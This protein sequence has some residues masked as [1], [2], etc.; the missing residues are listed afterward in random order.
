MK[1]LTIIL[2]IIVSLGWTSAHAEYDPDSYF[3]GKTGLGF[4]ATNVLDTDDNDVGSSLGFGYVRRL[5]DWNL[6][7]SVRYQYINYDWKNFIHSEGD[8]YLSHWGINL[9]WRHDIN[10]VGEDSYFYFNAFVGANNGKNWIDDGENGSGYGAGYTSRLLKKHNIF[11]TILYEH[12]SQL[13]VGEPFNEH[14]E[15]HLDRVSV[16]AEWRF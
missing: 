16:M 15:S 2:F 8:S 9:E 13:L 10:Q 4:N 14:D 3:Y 12:Y 7:G 11:G 1:Q 6:F 5:T